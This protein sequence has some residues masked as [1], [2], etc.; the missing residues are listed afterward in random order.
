M[1]MNEGKAHGLP[2]IAFNVDYSPCYQS[3]IIKVEMLDYVAI[4][5]EIIKKL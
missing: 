1:V 4:A 2:F 5:K 3:G